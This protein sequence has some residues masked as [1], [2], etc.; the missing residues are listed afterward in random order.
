[1][2]LPIC[3]I[4]VRHDQRQQ[5]TQEKTKQNKKQKTLSSTTTCQIYRFELPVTMVTVSTYPFDVLIMLHC[6]GKYYEIHTQST[7]I[8]GAINELVAFRFRL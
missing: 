8:E 4:L 7:S 2:T 5:A 6:I 3:Q 1:M